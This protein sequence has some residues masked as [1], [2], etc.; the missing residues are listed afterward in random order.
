MNNPFEIIFQDEYVVVLNKIAKILVQPSPRKEKH[1]LTSLLAQRLKEPVLPCHRLDR[2]TSGL[3]IYAKDR[4]SQRKIMDEFRAGVVRKKYIAFIRG[5]LNKKKGK[6]EG[7]ILDK[8]GRKFGEKF[9]KAKTI[10]SVLRQS[11]GFSVV[12]VTP[13]TGRTNQLRIQFSK[14][15]HPILGERK[16][17]LGRD[18]K[19]NFRRLALHAFFLSFIHPVSRQR[20]SL[21]IGLAVDM[22]EF[23]KKK[24][25]NIL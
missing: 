22:K 24:G 7:Y 19:V 20:V 9:K 23:L 14:L 10:Y 25:V 11:P 3:I 4:N 6:L 21:D 5:E 16:Y 1:T 8:E 18:F 15:G 17:A 12:E 13:L 2:E